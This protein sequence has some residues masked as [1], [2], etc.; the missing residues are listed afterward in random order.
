VRFADG[1]VPVQEDVMR[2]AFRFA[3]VTASLVLLIPAARA[4]NARAIIEKGIAAH[5]GAE[6][7]DKRQ[8]VHA[9][10]KSRLFLSGLEVPMLMETY[11][12]LPGRFKIIM[13]MDIQG[14]KLTMVQVLDGDQGW[15]SINGKTDAANEAMLAQLKDT[16]FTERVVRLTPLLRDPD[17]E[18]TDLG[19]SQFEGQAVLGVKVA[20]KGFNDM[21][22][23]FDKATGLLV[24]TTRT[25]IDPNMKEVVQEDVYSDFRDIGGVKRPMKVRITHDGQKFLEGE[26]TEVR[27]L[28]KLDDSV[29][30]RP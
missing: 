29:F 25:A 26:M 7:I 3:A 22:L 2:R 12:H 28:D 17:F 27:P 9:K 5:G 4:Q 6:Q 18:L 21:R 16:Q 14:M 24:R 1:P 19:E 20:C 15:V 23:F 8:A 30:A 10:A 13:E 11:V